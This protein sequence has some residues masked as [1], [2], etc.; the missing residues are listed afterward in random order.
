MYRIL[1]VLENNEEV[2]VKLRDYS[3]KEEVRCIRLQ[4]SEL[5]KQQ[6]V[7]LNNIYSMGDSMITE[8]E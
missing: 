5:N 2:I 7:W 4:R 1:E 8:N 3:N 6:E